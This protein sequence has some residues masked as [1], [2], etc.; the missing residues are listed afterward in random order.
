[1]VTNTPCSA[2]CFIFIKYESALPARMSFSTNVIISPETVNCQI[3]RVES[4]PTLGEYWSS[5]KHFLQS[6]LLL[7]PTYTESSVTKYT[8]SLDVKY[9]FAA[10]EKS[11]SQKTQKIEYRCRKSAY[12][13]KNDFQ[14]QI[15]SPQSR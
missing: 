10:R 8:N 15:E 9:R 6:F 1:M 5:A 11:I 7:S 12:Q 2:I 13:I 14:V 4:L 3:V